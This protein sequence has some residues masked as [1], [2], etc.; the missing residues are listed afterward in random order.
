MQFELEVGD[1]LRTVTVQ[2]DGAMFRVTVDGHPYLVDL[3][4]IDGATLSMLL[5]PNG[6]AAARRS[7]DAA[8][9]A[10]PSGG[11]FDVHVAGHSVPVQL[12]NGSG[13]RRLGVGS[14]HGAGPQ[15]VTAP[16]PGKIV[17]VLVKAGDL[18]KARQGLVVIE[19]MKMENELKAA[20]DGRIREVS[21]SEGQSVDAG[22]AL[23]IVE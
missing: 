19:A 22:A 3:R 4:R 23:V 15:R 16:M 5:Q 8:V 17:R 6:H 7:V 14:S 9:V 13:L 1:S 2:R 20:R 21:A 12:R 11:A 18:V 10:G